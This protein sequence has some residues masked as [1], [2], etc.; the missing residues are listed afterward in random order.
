MTYSVN[1]VKDNGYPWKLSIRYLVAE[2]NG[3]EYP[4]KVALEWF[5]TQEQ[6]ERARDHL[7]ALED[8]YEEARGPCA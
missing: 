8:A 5:R 1:E 3:Q 7:Q 4:R 2:P 6:A